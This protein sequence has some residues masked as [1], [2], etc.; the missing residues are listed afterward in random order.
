MQPSE[1]H[2]CNPS[3]LDATNCSIAVLQVDEAPV[4]KE[5][6]GQS[7]DGVGLV[8]VRSYPNA[9]SACSVI[10]ESAATLDLLDHTYLLVGC[11]I[12]NLEANQT[13]KTSGGHELKRIGQWMLFAVPH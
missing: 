9:N 10:G 4:E 13:L 1:D 8:V 3:D 7:P 2:I 6:F 12:D 11:P 5:T